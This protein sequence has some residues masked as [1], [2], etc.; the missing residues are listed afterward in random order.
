MLMCVTQGVTSP[1]GS[2]LIM[3]GLKGGTMF[4]LPLTTTLL[5]FGF[6]VFW[7]LYT[8]GFFV[9]TR[10]WSEEADES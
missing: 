2:D 4:G 1:Y 6:P 5:I 8:I 3:A 7:V 9:A 10:H